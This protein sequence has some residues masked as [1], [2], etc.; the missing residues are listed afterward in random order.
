MHGA[1]KPMWSHLL[2]LTRQQ[3]F[4][5]TARLSKRVCPASGKAGLVYLPVFFL[6]FVPERDG[7]R[8]CALYPVPEIEGDIASASRIS[9]LISD[10]AERSELPIAARRAGK[11]PD[12]VS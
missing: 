6:S 5:M 3:P 1:L 4:K 8:F 7:R 12:R 10:S 2:S 9:V 11:P